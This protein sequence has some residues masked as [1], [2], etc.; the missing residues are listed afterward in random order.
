[1]SR[2]KYCANLK[3]L[4][5]DQQIY[6]DQ[7]GFHRADRMNGFKVMVVKVSANQ[8]AAEFTLK[9]IPSELLANFH[10]NRIN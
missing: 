8:V 5:I 9:I 2:P 7:S 6:L 1:M 10:D 3:T 4:W